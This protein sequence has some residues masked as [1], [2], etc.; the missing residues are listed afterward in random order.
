MTDDD[1]TSWFEPLYAQKAAAGDA[2]PWTRDGPHG[3]L[4]QWVE[5]R[6]PDGGHAKSAIV[7]GC[8]LGAD[9]E[10]IASKGYN[11]TAFDLSP[12]A[13]R[14]A[15]EQHPGTPV[16][17]Q[18]QDLLALPAEWHRAFD[19]VVEVWTVQALPDPPRTEAI[20]AISDLTAPGGTLITI[21]V[22]R[23]DDAGDNAPDDGPPWFLNAATIAKFAHDGVEPRE[24]RRVPDPEAPDERRGWRAELTRP[25]VTSR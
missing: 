2:P 11:T 14:L 13:I 7:V 15:R 8:G 12:T 16:D 25:P 5:E 4:A 3:L 19:L 10:Y 20:H 17:Y 23:D 9:A 24:I 6:L 21:A 18:V 22:A 1:A